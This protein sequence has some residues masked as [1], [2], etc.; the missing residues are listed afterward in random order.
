MRAKGLERVESAEA[1]LLPPHERD[2]R[3]AFLV[4]NSKWTV[5][6]Y[7]DFE[8]EERL[9]YELSRNRRPFLRFMIVDSDVWAYQLY[10]EGEIVSAF[11][12]SSGIWGDIPGG[13]NDLEKLRRELQLEQSAAELRKLQRG[14]GP[15]A[16]IGARRFLGRLGLSA[17]L[18]QFDY[19]RQGENEFP[20][21]EVRELRYQRP[22]FDAMQGFDLHR[23]KRRE[24]ALVEIED[25]VLPGAAESL[26]PVHFRLLIGLFKMLVMLLKPFSPLFGW[27]LR[28]RAMAAVEG[29][30]SDVPASDKGVEALVEP[31]IVIEDGYLV[32]RTMGFRMHCPMGTELPGAFGLLRWR[33]FDVRVSISRPDHVREALTGWRRNVKYR[34]ED[35][36][37]G[38]LPARLE[39]VEDNSP[40]GNSRWACCYLA[41]TRGVYRFDY[42]QRFQKAGEREPISEEWSDDLILGWIESLK[43]FELLDLSSSPPAN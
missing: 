3:G 43:S 17:A 22:G 34:T 12:S 5:L 29:E 41:S 21:F 37:A 19:I 39:L 23:I 9:I 31:L 30:D 1:R 2:E 38:E 6:L 36:F 25:E 42:W 16:E 33:G 11:R 35:F 7:S 14:R 24:P 28:R 15:L 32:H 40:R 18:T 20:G 13:P 10:Q 8:E 4:W 27:I 26:L